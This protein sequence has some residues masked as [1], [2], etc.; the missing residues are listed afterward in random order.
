MAKSKPAAKPVQQA[1]EQNFVDLMMVA[2][3]F[4]QSRGGIEAAKLALADSGKFIQHA[5]SAAAAN[6]A[7]E[8]LE[9][10]KTKITA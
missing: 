6:R 2:A 8:V 4:V 9:N 3:D 1:P 7:L 10:L 5:G